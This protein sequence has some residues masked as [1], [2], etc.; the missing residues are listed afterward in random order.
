MSDTPQMKDLSASDAEGEEWRPVA[1]YEKDYEVSSLGRIRRVNPP[2][3]TLSCR[4]KYYV[5]GLKGRTEYVHRMVL[6]A[7][8]GSP[9]SGAVARHLNGNGRDN[10]L[11]N[12]A[13]G[14]QSENMYDVVRHGRHVRARSPEDRQQALAWLRGGFSR[15]TIAER[16]MAH[17]STVGKW[18]KEYGRTG[19]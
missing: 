8:R 4:G 3:S 2:M 7:F 9:P 19:R 1:G 10:R 17:P 5:V 15:R 12:L 16:L 6:K 11:E 18:I 14:T 13:W